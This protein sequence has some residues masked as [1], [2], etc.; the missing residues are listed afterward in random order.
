MK[1]IVRWYVVFFICGTFYLCVA[2][3]DLL[4]EH[5]DEPCE[6]DCLM[7]MDLM[8]YYSC[9]HYAI[10]GKVKRLGYEGALN[11]INLRLYAWRLLENCQK[12]GNYAATYSAQ[13]RSA[14][15]IVDVMRQ[16]VERFA[17]LEESTEIA[18]SV[19]V[20][21]LS[22]DEE[23][24]RLYVDEIVTKILNYMSPYDACVMLLGESITS[25]K[26]IS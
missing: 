5:E 9:F 4:A 26:I 19:A 13:C 10:E 11:Q 14:E 2:P 16:G 1:N 23:A 8:P 20:Y 24:L 25:A 18:L 6:E 17:A 21:N 12:N 15:P 22:A 3:G 7:D